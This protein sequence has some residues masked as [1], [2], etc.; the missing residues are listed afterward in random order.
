MRRYQVL[1]GMLLS[2]IAGAAAVDPE[3]LSIQ[4]LRP[5]CRERHPSVPPER[6]MIDDRLSAQE[7]AKRFGG[8]VIVIE[9]RDAGQIPAVPAEDRAAT[10]R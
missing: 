2:G 1:A 4:D 7:Y 6:C 10:V 3:S 9:P 5:E 8:A